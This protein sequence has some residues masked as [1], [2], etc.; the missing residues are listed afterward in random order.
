MISQSGEAAKI[1][2]KHNNPRENE[3]IKIVDA[4]KIFRLLIE[5]LMKYSKIK[6]KAF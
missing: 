4:R 1:L 3:S 5:S 6:L 2:D